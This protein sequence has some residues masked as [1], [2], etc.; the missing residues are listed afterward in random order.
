[1][2]CSHETG[3]S[4]YLLSSVFDDSHHAVARRLSV[5]VVVGLLCVRGVRATARA[6]TRGDTRA[7]VTAGSRMLHRHDALDEDGDEMPACSITSA[8]TIDSCGHRI[9]STA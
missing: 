3:E 2:S 1:V 4:N 5:A 9:E 6:S 8:N 7:K